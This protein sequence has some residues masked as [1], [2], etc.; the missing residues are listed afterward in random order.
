MLAYISAP[1]IRHGLF[2]TVSNHRSIFLVKKGTDGIFGDLENKP[3]NSWGQRH[4]I[5]TM[6][7]LFDLLTTDV[8][9]YPR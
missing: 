5:D 4:P 7:G 6:K 2:L 3:S 1:W 9:F 8:L